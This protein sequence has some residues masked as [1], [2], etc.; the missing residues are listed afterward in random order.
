MGYFKPSF[1]DAIKSHYSNTWGNI[2]SVRKWESGPIADL[3]GD[4]CVLEFAP[5]D[6]RQM[7]TYT[8]IATENRRAAM[9]ALDRSF[10][11]VGGSGDCFSALS[12]MVDH[13][14]ACELPQDLMEFVVPTLGLIESIA[15]FR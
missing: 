9:V 3:P 15:D 7:W 4:F 6:V 5:T 14:T 11:V 1:C 2:P 8:I 10:G 12:F 13:Q